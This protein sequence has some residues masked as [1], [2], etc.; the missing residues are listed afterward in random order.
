MQRDLVLHV[1]EVHSNASALHRLRGRVD[2][3]LLD[4][5]VEFRR[6]RSSMG[7]PR[8]STPSALPK[9]SDFMSP[10]KGGSSSQQLPS[11]GHDK[12]MTPRSAFPMH[13]ITRAGSSSL[14]VNHSSGKQREV[15][16][17]G[18][19]DEDSYDS[20]IQI[21]DSDPFLD[22]DTPTKCKK[23]FSCPLRGAFDCEKTFSTAS[24]AEAHSGVHTNAK[25]KC[26]YPDCEKMISTA[27]PNTMKAHL[28]L[29]ER[30]GLRAA[31]VHN[32]SASKLASTIP[33]TIPNS[34]TPSAEPTSSAPI[35]ISNLR[36]GNVKKTEPPLRNIVDPSYE[37][38]DEEEFVTRQVAKIAPDIIKEA[39]I[40]PPQP[41]EV[42]VV[43][44]SELPSKAPRKS[45]NS[46]AENASVPPAKVTAPASAAIPSKG[47]GSTK[48]P[49]AGRVTIQQVARPQ[50]ATPV[51]KPKARKSSGKSGFPPVAQSQLI[52]PAVE[53][54][55]QKS[56]GTGGSVAEEDYDE[57]SLGA[58]D[59]TLIYSRPRVNPLPIPRLDVRVKREG[60]D[61]QESS[62]LPVRKRRFSTYE[63]I[64]DI[65]ELNAD[66]PQSTTI[67]GLQSH[68]KKE[69]DDTQ[70]RSRP[71]LKPKTVRGK[72]T[73][74]EAA[75]SG[76][77]ETP[78]K[79][80]Q[81]P[82]K[83]DTPLIDL[84]G[85]SSSSNAQIP[86]DG[87]GI[88]I[89]STSDLGSSPTARPAR[90]RNQKSNPSGSP[91]LGLLTPAKL[92]SSRTIKQEGDGDVFKTPGGTFRRCGEDGLACGRPFC[93]KCGSA[94]VGS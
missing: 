94:V 31:P 23:G 83:V 56:S 92:L 55:A 74:G 26:S 85:H 3:A 32:T 19:V 14:R 65:D 24:S 21:L 86:G 91:L 30:D 68:I 62:E 40:V 59:F 38:S 90:T 73:S 6:P 35:P 41:T 12:T 33:S 34:Q 69:Q 15:N 36:K 1:R 28:K 72:R 27:Q 79:N 81:K 17:N 42:S 7:A 2:S 64:D 18:L 11:P 4:Q 66:A 50:L 49:L 44:L 80:K 5:G 22:R 87:V 75:G 29:H 39:S 53:P 61:V 88:S 63:G 54:K 48:K 58:D 20:D 9:D 37:F 51:V 10:P 52:S 46:K 77:L 82:A 70:R 13:G 45:R 89:P 84:V 76:S 60:N 25:V 57:L 78:P 16:S 47:S 67:M 93:F 71:I 43:P 8:P